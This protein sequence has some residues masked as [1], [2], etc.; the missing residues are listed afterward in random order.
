M[1]E[2]RIIQMALKLFGK[3]LREARKAR[4]Y[5]QGELGKRVKLSVN[6]ISRYERGQVSPT[7]ENFVKIVEIL[8]VSSDELLFEH[9]SAPKPQEPRNLKLWER[10]LEIEQ[11]D[12]RDQEAVIRL[13][14]AMVAKSKIRQVVGE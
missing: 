11:F 3:R 4:G 14:D 5:S 7:L 9:G 8:E 1:I 12:R 6:D 10:L 13:I 2:T